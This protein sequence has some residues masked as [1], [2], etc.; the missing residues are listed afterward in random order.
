MCKF[1]IYN[2]IHD[3]HIRHNKLIKHKSLKLYDDILI[4]HIKKFT[5]DYY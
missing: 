5:L 2:I 3:I 1:A 4:N